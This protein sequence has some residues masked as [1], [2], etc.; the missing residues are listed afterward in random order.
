MSVFI[1]DLVLSYGLTTAV[2]VLGILG[3]L[4]TMLVMSRAGLRD[5]FN[6]TITSLAVCDFFFLVTLIFRRMVHIMKLQG[7]MLGITLAAY[8]RAY[9][10][11]VS[12]LFAVLAIMHVYFISVERFCAVFFPFKISRV[13]TVNRIRIYLTLLYVLFSFCFVPRYLLEIVVWETDTSSNTSMPIVRFNDLFLYD[14]KV[15][16][17]T[18]AVY[19][20][21]V[22]SGDFFVTFS[23]VSISLRM[24]SI[25]RKRMEMNVGTNT[26]LRTGKTFVGIC[27][28]HM[29]VQV[30]Y[31][32]GTVI[33][34]I[35]PED[36]LNSETHSFLYNCIHLLSSL[37][38]SLNF[39]VYIF[40]APK[41]RPELKSLLSCHKK[42]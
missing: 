27:I 7:G 13:F 42:T 4:T 36:F 31:Y 39:I 25:S 16:Y 3:N 2:S 41:F 10:S 38:S 22:I 6:V 29:I 17:Y 24:L 26:S 8:S 1:A 18:L 14:E 20:T 28:V 37:K 19:F 35:L 34:T 11:A 21:L 33:V 23:S 5:V 40:L 30:P 15:Q 9:G 12:D 32:V